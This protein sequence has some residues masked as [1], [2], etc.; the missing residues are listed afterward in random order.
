MACSNAGAVPE[1]CGEA[2]VM[3]DPHSV[4]SIEDAVARILGDA[5]LRRKLTLAGPAR[6][7]MFSWKKSA[8]QTLNVYEQ[9]VGPRSPGASGLLTSRPPGVQL[10]CPLARV[11]F[12]EGNV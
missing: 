9:V 7:A 8:E 12:P 11:E 5:A 10:R 6:A 3:F 2:A 1:V 4:K